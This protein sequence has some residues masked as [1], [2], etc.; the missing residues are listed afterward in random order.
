MIQLKQILL[1]KKLKLHKP[2]PIHHK[3]LLKDKKNKKKKK[4]KKKK[5][6]KKKKILIYFPNCFSTE[7][8]GTYLTSNS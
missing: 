8:K 5:K 4:H 2:K 7:L 1:L 3:N 6:K